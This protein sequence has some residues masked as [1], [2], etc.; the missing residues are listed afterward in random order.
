MIWMCWMFDGNNLMLMLIFISFSIIFPYKF[1]ES[2][3]AQ[4]MFHVILK[5]DPCKFKESNNVLFMCSCNSQIWQMHI[6][7]NK[8]CSVRFHVMLKPDK[9]MSRFLVA[10]WSECHLPFSKQRSFPHLTQ[11]NSNNQ[12]MFNVC[13]YIIFK[14]N[15]CIFTET[16]HVQ[17]TANDILRYNPYKIPESNNVQFIFTYHSQTKQI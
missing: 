14:S 13:V 8:Q 3:H 10:V 2:N 17:L 5:Y 4:F 6:H 15:K 1:P 9:C 12:T 11:A 7:R 16:T